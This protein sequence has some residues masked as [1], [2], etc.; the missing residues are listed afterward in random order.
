MSAIGVNIE[1]KRFAADAAG[2]TVIEG[3][4]FEVAENEF[5]CVLGPSG[6]GKTT[7]LN[8][9]A[10][11]DKDYRGTISLPQGVLD[12]LAYVFQTP[13]LLPW[14]TVLQNVALVLPDDASADAIAG[15]VLEAVGMARYAGHFP[16]ELS[17][18]MQ[19]RVAL[20]R[21]LACQP[22]LMLMDEPFVSLDP[23]AAAE[24]RTLLMAILRDRPATVLF[25]THDYREAV[26][27]ADRI[28][29]LSKGPARVE[30]VV[31]VDLD[32]KQRESSS[33]I[34]K[35]IAVNLR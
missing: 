12:N 7:L 26:Q 25:V 14:R 11:L 15:D 31:A 5:V 17:V 20:A 27:L 21:A 35:F 1:A 29:V 18:G 34:D 8:I 22:T 16:T 6:C 19:R 23:E 33:R 13:R 30:R 28:V 3:L 10:G 4:D 24:L 32:Q 2:Q 9:I